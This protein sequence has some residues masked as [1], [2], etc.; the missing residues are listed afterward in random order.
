[1]RRAA[2][3]PET[4]GRPD[5]RPASPYKGLVPFDDSET[6][7]VLFFGRETERE[8]IAAN[9]KAHSLTVLY[10]PSGVGK[11]SVLRAGVVHHLR[12]EAESNIRR[13]GAPEFGAVYFADWPGDPHAG[14]TAAVAGEFG[15]RTE[16]PFEPS[17]AAPLADVLAESAEQLDGTLYVVL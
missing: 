8:I 15:R 13:F 16:A 5:V 10:G 3:E 4:R 12:R 1:M 9:L 11:S 14:L 6:D 2:L 7:A 17:A